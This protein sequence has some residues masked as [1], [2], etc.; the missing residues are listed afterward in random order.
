MIRDSLHRFLEQDILP[1]YDSFDA[2]HG[3]SHARTVISHALSAGTR[4][5]LDEEEC[6]TAAAYH[7]IGL[8]FG[9]ET[10]HL[11]SARL[12]RGDER[13]GEWFTE[14]RIAEMADA[15]EDHRASAERP[16]RTL[17]GK[18]LA[19]AD[20]AFTAPGVFARTM[21]YGRA[22]FPEL[23]DEAQFRRTYDHILNKY[24][25]NGYLS[26]LLEDP[27]RDAE[28]ETIF[29][30]LDDETAFRDACV[31][32]GKMPDEQL[33]P[34]RYLKRIGIDAA[35]PLPLTPGTLDLLQESH[36]RTVPYENMDILNGIPLSQDRRV[37]FRKIVDR[38]RGGYCFELNE[39]FGYLLRSNGFH[40]R[41]CFAR[42]LAGEKELPMRRHHVLIVNAPGSA[43]R[44]LCDVGVGS[45]SPARPVRLEAG[46]VQ[47]QPDA[48]WKLTK[49]SYLGWILW[50]QK[51]GEWQKVFS[52]TE[53]AQLSVDYAAASFYCEHSDASPFNKAPMISL[54]TA[55]GRITL[56]GGEYRVFSGDTVTVTKTDDIPRTLAERFGIHL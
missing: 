6:L 18:V 48:V 9:R 8:R 20:H 21:A 44:Y 45:G 52:F 27:A 38:R 49:D 42:F 11:T 23:D 12:M 33:P 28:R 43:D 47:A 3:L 15:V 31:R 36:L 24:G 1:L 22:H 35:F 7:D 50:Q 4:Y 2:A 34:D 17:L 30:L 32:F 13:L 37:L 55:D 54:R 5:G 40:V 51:H 53:E 26:F 39:L 41:D 16:P 25:R 14:D 46:A 29:R 56:D 19:D 10:H